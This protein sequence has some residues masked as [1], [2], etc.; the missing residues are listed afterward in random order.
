MLRRD[1]DPTLEDDSHST[2]DAATRS[3]NTTR[4]EALHAIVRY[5]LWVHRGLAPTDPFKRLL[6]TE[7]R[8]VLD[9]HLD[10]QRDP[11]TAVRA[12]YGQW[13]PWLIRLDRA[14]V[15]GSLARI[16]PTEPELG[17]LRAAAWDTYVTF[18]PAHDE[19]FDV[20]R[21]EYFAAVDALGREGTGRRSRDPEASLGE[22]L[23]MLTARGRVTWEDETGL[24]RSFFAKASDEVAQ[25][26]LAFVG[27]AIRNEHPPSAE[28]MNRFTALWD[29]ILAEVRSCAP[30]SKKALKAFGWWFGSGRF[31]REWSTENLLEVLRL[32]GGVDADFLVF[33]ELERIAREAPASAVKVLRELIRDDPQGWGLISSREH[34]RAVLAA[35]LADM[36]A[37]ERTREVLHELGA[38]GHIEFRDLLQ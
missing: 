16:F 9:E 28:V 32:V 26:A 8:Q 3:I 17:H 4:G 5:A 25:H 10:P 11:S 24:L 27:R 36:A 38:R 2:M 19:P 21:S 35:G 37:A 30:V 1:P 29:H 23:M 12:V 7:V 18:C 6:P 13:L 33:E 14:W 31:R 15:S 34:V 20:L 22:H